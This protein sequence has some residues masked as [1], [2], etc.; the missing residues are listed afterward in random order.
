MSPATGVGVGFTSLQ[1]RARI[2]RAARLGIFCLAALLA[3]FASGADEC[4]TSTTARRLNIEKSTVDFETLEEKRGNYVATLK[5]GDLVMASFQQCGLGMHAHFYSRNP[6]APAQRARTLRWVLAAVAPG[7]AVYQSL[8]KQMGS[9][10]GASDK[11]TYTFSDANEESHVFEFKASESP[12][13]QT[14]VHYT[15]NPPQH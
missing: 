11:T 12:L 10:M 9:V 15:W 14:V 2:P 5:N 1:H 4:E 8:E 6:V 3:P 7:P 13:F